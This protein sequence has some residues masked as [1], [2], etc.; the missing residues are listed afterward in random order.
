MIIT[1]RT[2][3]FPAWKSRLSLVRPVAC[4][5]ILTTMACQD[6]PLNL[7]EAEFGIVTGSVLDESLG[8][9]VEG[10]IVKAL[11]SGVIDTTENNGAFRLD[12]LS[13][14]LDTLAVTAKYYES[15]SYSL[16]VKPGFQDVSVLLNQDKDLTCFPVEDTSRTYISP[17]WNGDTVWVYP[18][19]LFVRFYPWVTVDQIE[20]LLQQYPLDAIHGIFTMEGQF[21]ANICITDESRAECYFTPY[22]RERWDNFGADSLV[23]YSFGIFSWWYPDPVGSTW[24]P[25]GSIVFRFEDGTTEARIDSLFDA[26]GL[27]LL[28]TSPYHEGGFLYTTIV[29]PEATR[30]V[31]DLGHEL[32]KIP[33]V[34]IALVD[35][36]ASSDPL[37]CD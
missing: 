28:H 14:G 20:A 31:L 22:G 24:K 32:K 12:S 29:T 9:A 1:T 17:V 6:E 18:N 2:R 27:R 34:D 35:V 30:N 13:V 26:E 21:V 19:A 5:V 16:D 25:A 36:F 15:Q 3:N 37:W 10:A 33:F 23:E 4:L 8:I 7:D 11:K